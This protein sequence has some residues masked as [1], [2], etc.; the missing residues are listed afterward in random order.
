MDEKALSVELESLLA[1]IEG[2]YPKER[3]NRPIEKCSLNF[4]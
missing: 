1:D 4:Y 3:V 2:E